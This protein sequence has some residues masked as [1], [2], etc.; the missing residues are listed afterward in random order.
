M[1]FSF[2]NTFVYRS[3]ALT[4]RG[5]GWPVP[6]SLY[7]P[8]IGERTFQEGLEEVRLADELGFDWISASEHH[9]WSVA[10][11][12]NPAVLIGALTQ[13]VKNAKLAFMG[14]LVSMNNPIR[15]AEEVAMLD[16]MSN[17]RLIVLFLRGTPNE[18]LA[19]DVVP[20]ETRERT[21]EAIALITRALT[22]P[23]PFSWEGRHFRYRTISVWPGVSQRPM[24]LMFA[25]GNSR[26]SATFAARHKYCMAMAYYPS[27]LCAEL[28]DFYKAE[29]R[30]YGWEPTADQ[31]LYRCFVSAGDDDEQ[32]AERRERYFG[33]R[34]GMIGAPRKGRAEIIADQQRRPLSAAPSE[35]G[36]DADG[37]KMDDNAARGFALGGLAFC[38]GPETLVEQI[39]DFVRRTGVG[40][41]DLSLNGGGLTHEEHIHSL[42]LF[43]TQVIPRLRALDISVAPRQARAYVGS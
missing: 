31:I 14:P 38:G 6:S 22:E 7:E 39:E 28:V 29:C 1:K 20:E 37:K 26:E 36:T 25:S 19:Y 2:F 41:I 11:T 15:I 34:G 40:V 42:E 30:G 4:E 24:P 5:D 27:H 17:G 18:F 35:V 43:G 16:Q 9:Y 10:P 13:V 3:Q 32:A 8:A 12:P 23:E 33:E 21:Q